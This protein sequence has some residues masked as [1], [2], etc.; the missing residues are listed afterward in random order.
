MSPVSSPRA[1]KR[2]KLDSP[3]PPSSS[4]VLAS[5]SS[6]EDNC[7]IC[8]Q[9]ILDRTIL[10][11]CS[12]EFCFECILVWSGQ[13]ASSTLSLTPNTEGHIS[14]R[15]KNNPGD[16]LSVHNFSVVTLSTTFVQSMTTKNIIYLRCARLHP[17]VVLLQQPGVP[18]H[19]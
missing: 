7:S 5:T 14:S 2:I 16:V 6:T 9:P 1:Q 15:Q 17:Q 13:S 8:L 12:H 18:V 19:A 3:S 10:P 11:A 4:R